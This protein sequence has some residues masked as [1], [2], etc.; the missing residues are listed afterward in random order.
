MQIS[1]EKIVQAIKGIKKSLVLIVILAFIIGIYIYNNTFYVVIRFDELGP[2]VKNMSAYYKGFKIG[3]IVK[4]GPDKDFKHTLVRVNLTT[5]SIKLPQ[6]TIVYVEKFPN[7]EL[8]LQF[9]YPT[10]PSLNLIKRGDLLEGMSPYS[11]EQFM[12]G[13]SVSGMSDIVSL[14]I[15]RA[16]D[17]ADAAN[18]EMRVFFQI[19]SKII[20]TNDKN[21]NAS[22]SNTA[23][24]TKNLAQMAENL[25][26]TSQKINNAVDEAILKDTL[27]GIKDITINISDA[28]KDMDK[29]MKKID[30]TI[31]Q[32]N[33]TAENLNSI[34]SGLNE[35]L[36]KRFAGVRIMFGTPIKSKN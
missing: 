33:A 6:N 23:A 14:H 27:S 4:I 3:R 36:G 32:V 21:I 26:Q 9:V 2:L 35:T 17:S 24:M 30:D 34:T 28:T 7:G 1:S 18:Q 29:T 19:A 31:V 25:N 5:S 16:L 12:M 8:Y 13:Q 20:K 22:M 11:I 10:S 15:I